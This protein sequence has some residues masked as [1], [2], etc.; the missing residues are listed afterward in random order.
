MVFFIYG[1]NVV[2]HIFI[3]NNLLNANNAKQN[4]TIYTRR[5]SSHS[6]LLKHAINNSINYHRHTP[7]L[8][9]LVRGDINCF[10]GVWLV[11]F[12]R[13]RLVYTAT[14]TTPPDGVAIS[15]NTHA[16]PKVSNS[17]FQNVHDGVGSCQE[18]NVHQC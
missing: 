14:A 5:K 15:I 13:Q 3:R 11:H 4:N 16:T 1:I 8:T 10:N 17:A 18:I 9:I 2:I 12:D 6:S 7:L